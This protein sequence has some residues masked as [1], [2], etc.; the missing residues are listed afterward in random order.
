MTKKQLPR[1]D[2]CSVPS[3]EKRC[4]STSGKPSKACP[5]LSNSKL[6]ES[7]RKEYQKPE[8]LEFAR[9]AAIQEGDCYQDKSKKPFVMHPT[10]PR[11]QEIC[12][13]ASK[14]KYRHLGLVSCLGLSREA[15]V[16]GE[17]LQA[18]GFDVTS[19]ICKAGAV[20]KEEIRVK[21][22]EKVRIG[23]YESMCNPIYQAMLLNDA[24]T[25]FNVLMG[26]CVGHDALFFKYAE[27]P[28]T[29]LAVKDRLLGHNPLAAIY[30]SDTFYSRVKRKGF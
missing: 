5:T 28:T 16:V 15:S 27:A 8:I 17:I 7:A 14:M 3:R 20:P 9:Q 22:N 26:L 19:V 25:E 29:V 13:F 21:E 11:I 30:T 18:Q 1:C 10:K 6:L 12:E 4:V 24:K 2:Q 23:E